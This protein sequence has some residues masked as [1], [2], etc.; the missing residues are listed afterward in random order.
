MADSQLP[1]EFTARDLANVLTSIEGDRY[2]KLKESDYVHWLEGNQNLSAV[3]SF[4]LENKKLGYWAER[5][6]LRSHHHSRRAENLKYFLLTIKV[7]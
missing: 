4:I 1:D 7:S 3:S 2:R 5:S 6:I